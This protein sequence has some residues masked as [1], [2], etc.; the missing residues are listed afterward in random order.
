MTKQPNYLRN[1]ILSAVAGAFLAITAGAASAAGAPRG[2]QDETTADI[3]VHLAQ[4]VPV[5]AQSFEPRG[6]HTQPYRHRIRN[7][8]G[9]RDHRPENE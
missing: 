2:T 8:D 4:R 7:R 1:V 6:T 5:K 9:E 3:E